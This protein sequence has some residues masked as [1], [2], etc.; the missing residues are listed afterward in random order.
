M[1]STD[2]SECAEKQP[3]KP[4]LAGWNNAELVVLYVLETHPLIGLPVEEFTCK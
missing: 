2:G 1:L 3:N 4:L